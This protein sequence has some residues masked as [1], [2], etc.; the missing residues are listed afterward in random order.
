MLSFSFPNTHTQAWTHFDF[1]KFILEGGSPCMWGPAQL[2]LQLF[3]GRKLVWLCEARRKGKAENQTDS[4]SSSLVFVEDLQVLSIQVS[5]QLGF[6]QQ[7]ETWWLITAI[8]WPNCK[9]QLWMLTGQFTPN[10]KTTYSLTCSDI[11]SRHA[12]SF[13]VIWFWYIHLG[14]FCLHRDTVEVNWTLWCW[15]CQ[16]IH[17]IVWVSKVWYIFFLCARELHCCPEL[18]KTHQWAAPLHVPSLLRTHTL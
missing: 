15:D 4:P 5:M 1:A 2:H 8:Y 6:R 16:E 14:P 9:L 18:L 17:S 7:C 13:G 11:L 3:L 10:H 12:E